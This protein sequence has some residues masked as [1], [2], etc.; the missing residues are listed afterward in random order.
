MVVKP[1]RKTCLE[2]AG[3]LVA[4]CAVGVIANSINADG[5]QIGNDYFP[6]LSPPPPDDNGGDEPRD[7]QLP[8]HGLQSA[9]FEDVAEYADLLFES[10]GYIMILD[11]RDDASYKEGHIPGAL[12]VNHYKQDKYLPDIMT[13]LE[14]AGVIVVY[15][16]GGNCEDSILLATSLISQHGLPHENVYVYEGGIKEWKDRNQA[17]TEGMDP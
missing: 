7:D 15:C 11:A 9:S 14:E 13:M 3:I 16:N 1:I 12:Q 17:L 5:I 8:E 10:D 2:M 6:K 4:A